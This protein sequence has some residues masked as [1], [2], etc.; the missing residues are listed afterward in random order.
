M[1]TVVGVSTQITD[2]GRAAL[3]TA[4]LVVGG[5][6]LLDQVAALHPHTAR[7]VHLGPSIGEALDAIDAGLQ[8]GERVCVV[9]SGDPGWFGIVRALA[10]RFGRS[11]LVVHP[12]PSTV[13]VA[14][15]RLAMPWDDAVVVSAHGRPAE[16]AARLTARSPKAA[17]L[18]SPEN[19]A[20]RLGKLLVELGATHEHVAVCERLGG[21][22]ERVSV[23]DLAGLAAGRWDALSVVLLWSGDGVAREKSLA[24]GLPEHEFSHRGSMIT[25]SEVRAMVIGLLDLPPAATPCPVLWDIGA[26]S[27]SVAVECARLAPWIEVVAVERDAD[28]ASSCRDNARRH[29]VALRIC[30]GEAPDCLD[31]LPDP[32]RVFV[33]GGGLGVLRAAH[34][35]L[36][37]GGTI[38]ATFAA[39]DRAAEAA[40]LLGNL[41]QLVAS[42]GRRLPDG[43]WRLNATN[44]IFVCWGTR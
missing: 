20:E 3:A 4:D 18:T 36:R 21:G 43:G 28:S 30:E 6:R 34:D 23:T 39:I 33:G 37:T 25:K 41:T 9:A 15:A 26:G 14:F 29:A 31:T 44:P 8:S 10:E 40:E 32:D 2:A 42:R 12:A 19:P 24:W 5:P 1:I 16:M 7:P 38:V 11:V 27:A 17:I 35:R 13:S 22:D